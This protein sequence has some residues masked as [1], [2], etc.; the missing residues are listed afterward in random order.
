MDVQ[1]TRDRIE[2]SLFAVKAALQ[3]GYVVGAG[4]AII[5]AANRIDDEGLSPS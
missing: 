5:E 2:D 4:M 1:E 3:E